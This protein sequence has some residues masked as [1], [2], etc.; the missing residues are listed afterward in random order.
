MTLIHVVHIVFV[1][2]PTL[3]G[4]PAYLLLE[5]YKHRLKWSQVILRSA[6]LREIDSLSG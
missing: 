5:N 6:G 2:E 1:Q 4:N 3:N